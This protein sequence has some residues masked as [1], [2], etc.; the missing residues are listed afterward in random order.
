[1]QYLLVKIPATPF[2]VGSRIIFPK[3]KTHAQVSGHPDVQVNYIKKSTPFK[4][5]VLH[6]NRN[7][8]VNSTLLFPAYLSITPPPPHSIT[9]P[10][11]V[12]NAQAA[13][14][15]RFSAIRCTAITAFSAGVLYRSLQ[16]FNLTPTWRSENL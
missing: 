15:R 8:I 1:M 7:P 2:S 16:R 3:P 9:S 10:A 6:M 13:N 4:D 5:A 14:G 12:E 11:P